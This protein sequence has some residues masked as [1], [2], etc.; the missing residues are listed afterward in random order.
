M[1]SKY[2]EI[3]VN[4]TMSYVGL[5]NPPK[6]PLG[7]CTRARHAMCAFSATIHFSLTKNPPRVQIKQTG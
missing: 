3:N 5:R 2:A 7:A 4:Y 6:M 1:S